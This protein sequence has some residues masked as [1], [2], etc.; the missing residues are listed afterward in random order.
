MIYNSIVN[1]KNSRTKQLFVLIDPDKCNLDKINELAEILNNSTVSIVLVGG[2]L[3]RIQPDVI[4]SKLKSLVK[5]PVVLFPGSLIQLTST[6]DGILLLSLISGRNPELLI[7]NAIVAAPFLK[8]SRMEVIPTGYIL[9]DGGNCTSV[10]YISQTRPIPSSKT[11]IATATALAGEM[12][13]MKLIYLEA[14]SGAQKHVPEKMIKEISL[15]VSVP[16]IV[17]GGIKNIQQAQNI[18]DSGA[19]I[20]VIGSCV[21]NNY[22]KILEF[23]EFTYKYNQ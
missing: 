19:D 17:G 4:I 14:G 5:I 20:I 8:Q 18:F 2:S 22:K 10:E 13:G 11:D 7:G 1:H 9:I 15:N 3:T 23:S 6:A 16:I 12:M 21:E